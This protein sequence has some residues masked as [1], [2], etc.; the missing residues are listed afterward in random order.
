[1]N[2]KD[3]EV[4]KTHIKRVVKNIEYNSI[5]YNHYRQLA[6]EVD[7]IQSDKV[8][9]KAERLEDCNSFWILDQYEKAKIKDFKKTNLC[10]DK[11]CNNCK[12]VKQAQRMAKFIPLIRPYKKDMY[13]ITLTVPNVKGD[14]LKETIE[15]MFKSFAML[16]RY[17]NGTKEIKG[18][19]FKRWGFEG[20][21]RS[22]EITFNDDEYHPHLHALFV[23]KGCMSE[24]Q[25]KNTYSYDRY[26]KDN[27]RLFTDEEILIQKIWKLLN[28]GTRVTKKAIDNMKR[29]YSCTIDKFKEDDFLELFKYMTKSTGEDNLILTYEQFKT[30]YYTLFKTRQIQGY[31]CFYGL[32]DAEIDIEEI[33][34][35]YDSLIEDLQKEENPVEVFESP[36]ELTKNKEYI[37]ISRKKVAAFL[38]QLND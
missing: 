5:I 35:F 25:H 10:K 19:D 12:K 4:K 37:V 14:K 8:L 38:R 9:N 36:T 17:I 22:L 7:D 2:F 1:M 11:F 29:G 28:T 26:N 16:V 31:G 21:I 18:V 13:Q 23:F 33:N 30:L 27:I 24:K 32:K 15:T 3:I 6:S 34:D 20:A